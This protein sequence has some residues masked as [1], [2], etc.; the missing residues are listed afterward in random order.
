MLG[1]SI[2]RHIREEL[3]DYVVFDLETTGLSSEFDE[4]IEISAIKVIDGE[5][6]DEFSTLVKPEIKI[7]EAASAVN[8]ITEEMVKN[9]PSFEKVLKEFLDF[10]GNLTVVGHN[11]YG[12][13][14]KFI[15]RDCKKF[16]GKSF[17]N[18][19]SDTLILSRDYRPD[20]KSHTLSAMAQ[21]YS[22]PVI[23]AHRALND[24]VMTQ[25]VYVNLRYDMTTESMREHGCSICPECGSLIKKK[26]GKY[27]SFIGCTNYPTCKY[28][29]KT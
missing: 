27:G 29:S 15:D 12:F 3:K 7:S 9:A 25:Q 10:V 5:I 21:E 8:G 28:T 23:G 16:F 20:M 26:K 2:G 13:D 18:P 17:A 4:V 19:Y 14:L 1:D 22:I 11:V 6:A 24:C